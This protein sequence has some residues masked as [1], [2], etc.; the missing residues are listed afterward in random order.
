[1]SV[2]F[3]ALHESAHVQV[4][5]RRQRDLTTRSGGRRPKSAKARNRGRDARSA[6]PQ[7]RLWGFERGACRVG[8]SAR[9]EVERLRG[10]KRAGSLLPRCF[11]NRLRGR[12]LRL[13]LRKYCS[14]GKRL[15]VRW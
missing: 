13:S 12:G 3:A 5:G 11:P 1:M 6:V 14:F 9:R 7:A 10:V 4:F 15:V 8:G 2:F